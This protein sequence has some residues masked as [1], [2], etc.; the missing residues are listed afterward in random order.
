MSE[1]KYVI[2][3]GHNPDKVGACDGTFCEWPNTKDWAEEIATH[4]PSAETLVLAGAPLGQKI[5]QI[6]ELKPV[7]LFAIEVHFN[8]SAKGGKGS[9][10]LFTPGSEKSKLLA[11]IVQA[12]VSE[13]SLPNRGIKE[14]W[15]KMDFERRIP[16]GFLAQTRPVAIILEPY[17]IQQGTEIILKKRDCCALIAQ[18]LKE[19]VTTQFGV[20]FETPSS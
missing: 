10:T 2:S 3:A 17:F 19:F 13:I 5:K 11:E 1:I 6:N 20:S 14:G 16:D 9:E 7:P 12:R 18:A 15:Y 8:S 4:F